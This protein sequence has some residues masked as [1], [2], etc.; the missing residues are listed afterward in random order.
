MWLCLKEQTN[1]VGEYIFSSPSSSPPRH[2]CLAAWPQ[3]PVSHVRWVPRLGEAELIKSKAL[4]ASTRRLMISTA[5]GSGSFE[6]ARGRDRGGW[7][8]EG[9]RD[10]GREGWMGVWLVGWWGWGGTHRQSGWEANLFWRILSRSSGACRQQHFLAERQR[11]HTHQVAGPACHG[12][13][14]VLPR[15]LSVTSW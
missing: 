4:Q 5:P 10:G 8:G 12:P 9:G 11:C 2:S 1:G 7:V 3:S 6:K 14:R 15:D 13:L